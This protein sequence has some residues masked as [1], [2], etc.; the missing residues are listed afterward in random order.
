MGFCWW[1]GFRGGCKAPPLRLT[2]ILTGL[3][4]WSRWFPA[5]IRFVK[6]SYLFFAMQYCD[7]V[8]V[9]LQLVQQCVDGSGFRPSDQTGSRG[10]WPRDPSRTPKWGP[11]FCMWSYRNS[12]MAWES[13]TPRNPSLFNCFI[14][15][16]VFW[17]ANPRIFFGIFQEIILR[18]SRAPQIEI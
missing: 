17:A 11:A 6:E 18:G 15:F 7:I 16:W 13:E 3:V 4:C 12:A 2:K 9:I 14:I 10:E 5:E 8:F 1:W